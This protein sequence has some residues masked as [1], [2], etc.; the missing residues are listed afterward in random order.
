MTSKVTVTSHSNGY[1]VLVE[2]LNYNNNNPV[3]NWTALAT[4]NPGEERDFCL[5]SSVQF[6]IT[7]LPQL[8]DSEN[9][10]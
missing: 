6:K 9:S 7:E 4:V 3:G 10:S 1:P 5:H 2:Q 8:R